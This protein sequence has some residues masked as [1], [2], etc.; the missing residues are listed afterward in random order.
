MVISVKVLN[1][2][3]IRINQKVYCYNLINFLKIIIYIFNLNKSW[4]FDEII[5][6]LRVVVLF[7]KSKTW[8]DYSIFSFIFALVA[9]VFTEDGYI[10]LSLILINL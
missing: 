10:H 5:Y 6:H 8:C 4:R 2:V 7:R 3:F 1:Y 9:D